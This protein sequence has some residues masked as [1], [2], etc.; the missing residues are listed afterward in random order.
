MFV[1]SVSFSLTEESVLE[2]A[3]IVNAHMLYPDMERYE[4]GFLSEHT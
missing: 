2:L 3:F 4:E 1:L